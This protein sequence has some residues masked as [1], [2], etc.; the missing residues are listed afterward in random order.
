M[1]LMAKSRRPRSSASEATSTVGQ[2]PG[3][4]VGLPARR[5]QVEREL[6]RAH[7]RRAEALVLAGL[8][9]QA[10]SQLARGEAS[11]A[12]EG[13]VQVHRQGAP[14]QVAHGAP[15]EVGRRQP[16]ERRQHAHHAGQAADAFAQVGRQHAGH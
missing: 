13:D 15:D 16:L 14:D 3:P 8:P 6:A 4:L 5:G 10:L 12:L 2:R 7:R 1:A 11:V 9:A